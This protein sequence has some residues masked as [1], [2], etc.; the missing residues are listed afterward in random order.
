MP[1][2]FLADIFKLGIKCT[3]FERESYLNQRSRDWSFGIYWAHGP[4]GECL[5]EAIRAQLNTATVDPSRTPSPEDFIRMVNGETAEELF[6]VPMPNV[7]R[8]KRSSF[9]ALLAEGLNVQY[10]KK[11]SAISQTPNDKG[12]PTVTATFEDGSSATGNLLV[13]ADGAKSKVREYLLGSEKAA[14]Q[15][16]PIIGCHATL[17]LPADIARKLIAELDGQVF[18]LAFNPARICVF[19]VVHDIPDH[20]RPETWEWR[21]TITFWREGSDQLTNAAE[22]RKTWNENSEKM[23]EPF[24]SALLSLPDDAVIMCERLSQW[25]TMG[26]DNKQGSVTLAGDAA[27]PMTY[28]RGQGLNNAVHDAAYLGRAL[29]DH[30][31]NG[32]P[33]TDVLAAYEAEVVE[34]GNEAV[35][36]SGQNSVMLHDWEQLINSPLFQ[37]GAAP[38]RK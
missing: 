13:G 10:G 5:P 16:L 25:P 11:L 15:P 27:H 1:C 21:P 34:R 6:R 30:C 31:E 36:S 24:R 26:W 12:E 29:N 9:R 35:L 2:I 4:L 37:H 3:A 28:H 32:K 14:L 23:A 19:F 20:E 38:L 18:V 7:I 22:I 8:L 17:T 33:L